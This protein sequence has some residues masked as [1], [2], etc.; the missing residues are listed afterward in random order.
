[1]V[2]HGIYTLET[3]TFNEVKNHPSVSGELFQRGGSVEERLAEKGMFNSR[4]KIMIKVFYVI[5]LEK[6]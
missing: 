3:T 4:P 2:T 5:L 6:H 1:M